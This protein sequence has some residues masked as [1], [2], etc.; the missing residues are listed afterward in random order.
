VIGR[1][2][3]ALVAFL[4]QS[5]IAF[6][7]PRLRVDV[8]IAP[9]ADGVSA[10]YRLAQPV[11]R[12]RFEYADGRKL[13]QATWAVT[14]PGIALE[15]DEIKASDGRT[16][17]EF[18][19]AVTARNELA[20]AIYACVMKLGGEG[21]VVY[22]SYFAGDQAAFDTAIEFVPAA[23]GVVLGLPKDAAVLRV[24]RTVLASQQAANL[25]V[26]MG[27]RKHV[28]RTPLATYVAGPESPPWVQREIERL[29]APSLAFYREK[30]G[31]SLARPPLIMTTT[32]KGPSGAAVADVTE[33]PNVAFRLLGDPWTK[34]TPAA[35]ERLR[36]MAMH[37]YAHFWNSHAV[38]S[39]DNESARWLHEGGAEYW[40]RLAAAH[41][42]GA[43]VSSNA[44]TALNTCAE[45]LE[46]Q[47]LAAVR[48]PANYPCGEVVQW[49]AD[50]GQRAKSKDSFALWRELF[51]QAEENGGNYTAAMFREIAARDAPAVGEALALI[52][53]RAGLE[54]WAELP[55]LVAKL[56]VRLKTAPPSAEAR[57][58]AAVMHVLQGVCDGQHGYWREDGWL[59]FDTGER[60][61]PLSG[62]PEIDSANGHN[63]LTDA[64]GAA[65][66]IEDAC[67]A[68]AAVTFGRAGQ[69]A[70][71]TA[72][73]SGVVRA[74][75]PSFRIAE[76]R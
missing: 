59:K 42:R 50:L 61:G 25:Y 54:R 9:T 66:A 14:T 47:P 72:T 7:E 27:P 11:D 19:V 23:D 6:A 17:D 52:I 49:L 51:D 39:G 71:W 43:K 34:K 37:E 65:T 21:R 5:W 48:S 58:D 56:G 4:A 41:Q 24:D 55:K 2:L 60:C 73:C 13:R 75:P 36:H 3:L 68:N 26:Y 15:G 12:F 44:E 57:R 29:A 10:V 74:L 69:A 63:L 31:R 64:A 30:I 40:A 38:R 32:E 67:A 22:A 33:G 76:G 53:D 45:M 1:G 20:D 62:D 16:F 70:T 18:A 28:K 46:T 8:R 35:A